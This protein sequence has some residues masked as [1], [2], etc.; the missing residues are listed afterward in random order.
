MTIYFFISL[1]FSGSALVLKSKSAIYFKNVTFLATITLI[2]LIVSLRYETGTD[3]YN[4]LG[5]FQRL[6]STGLHLSEELGFSLIIIFFDYIG[7]PSQ[8]FFLLFAVMT[9]F[10]S[11]LGFKN[12]TPNWQ[13]VTLVFVVSA[14]PTLMG[15]FRLLLASSIGLFSIYY[16]IE[17]RFIGYLFFVILALLFHRAAVL[18]LLI[19]PLLIVHRKIGTSYTASILLMAA[20]FILMVENHVY[21]FIAMLFQFDILNLE[22]KLH[23][24]VHNERYG[25]TPISMTIIVKSVVLAIIFVILRDRLILKIK[26]Y[27]YFLIII[28]L[29]FIMQLFITQTIFGAIAL[30]GAQFFMIVQS[31]LLVACISA[32]RSMVEKILFL[33]FVMIVTF[34]SMWTTM[35]LRAELYFPYKSIIFN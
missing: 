35:I 27:D 1:V 23:N 8:S 25:S 10:F 12:L 2:V 22:Y 7:F 4:Y 34:G 29:G 26:Y 18:L 19:Y 31:I 13:I 14:L 20:L 6:P 9:V 30:R 24:Y 28:F 3:Y 17:R 16:A 21:S 33:F 5:W 32:M 11:A 15:G